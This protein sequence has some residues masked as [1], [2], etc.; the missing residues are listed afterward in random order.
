MGLTEKTNTVPRG[1][2]V[3]A[4]LLRPGLAADPDGVALVSADTRWTWRTLEALTSRLA[5]GLLEL[6][7]RPGDRI[8]SWMPN[9][10]LLIVHYLACFRAGLVA[11][12]L[13][14]RYMAPEV[15]HALRVSGARALLSH[16]E[17]DG[18]LASSKLAPHLQLGRISY[19][20]P[21]ESTAPAFEDLIDGEPSAAP[22]APSPPSAPAMIFFTS[23]S[24]ALPKGVTHT[25]E[26]LGWMMQIAAAGLELTAADVLLA[27]SSLSHVGAFY[28]TF[29]ALS[30]GTRVIV[31][32]TFDGD[33]LLPL[34]RE[35]RPT[36]L[37]MLPSA[38]F[39]LT[40]DHGAS[41]A[42]FASLRLCRAAGDKVSG[43]LEKEFTSLSG[44]VIDEA[45][46]LTETGLVAVSPPSGE[47][48]IGSVGRA[49]PGTSLSVRND[50]GEELPCGTEGRVWIKTPAATIGY[51]ENPEATEDLFNDGWLDSGDVMRADDD[52]YYFFFGRK[53]QIIVHDGSNISPQDVEGALIEHPCV[54]SVAVIGIHDLVHGENVRAYITL[55]E[56]AERPTSQELIRFARQRVGYKAPEEI[57]VVDDLPH[58]ATG[59]IDR[60]TLKRMAEANLAGA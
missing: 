27:G 23:G 51:W 44:R 37:S 50:A 30:V 54:G 55:K 4:D 34:L 52:G 53:K 33:E 58:T 43:E 17:R 59:K 6:G 47:I 48:R 18:D 14:Y 40:R 28:V 16:A 19:G 3:P 2:A 12:P 36:V 35:D 26:T 1:P 45:Y 60:T 31:A 13:N 8:A 9:C 46:G 22:F 15:D 21:T 29:A 7:L 5:Q 20:A 39:A 25:H 42:D 38:L 57:V 41:H 11:T 49:A 10:P 24:T 32:R 56:G